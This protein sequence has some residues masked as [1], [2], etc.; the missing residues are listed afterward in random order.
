[1]QLPDFGDRV[2]ALS[3]LDAIADPLHRAVNGMLP[4]GPAKDA[5]HGTWLGHPLHPVLTDLPIGFWT[6][7]WTLDVVGGRKAAPAAQKLIAWG[8]ISAAPTVVSGVA[9]WSELHR[10]E[11]RSGVV[12]AVANVAA[13]ALYAWSYVSRRRGRRG[14][15]IAIGMAGAAAATA[16]GYLG[17]HLSFKKG[18]ATDRRASP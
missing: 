11:R 18:P 2:D 13:T 8:V 10:P 15:G 7:A 12:H 3:Q 14:R 4:P 6:S 1:M 9:D 17:G 16:G 5:L